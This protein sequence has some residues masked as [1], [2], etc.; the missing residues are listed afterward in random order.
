MFSKIKQERRN[1]GT[2]MYDIMN[3]LKFHI[4]GTDS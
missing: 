3:A 4:L 2:E 1:K